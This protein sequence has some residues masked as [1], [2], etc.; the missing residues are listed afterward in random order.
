MALFLVFI[1]QKSF[2]LFSD[3]LP[4]FLIDLIQHFNISSFY[5]DMCHIFHCEHSKVF[6]NFREYKYIKITVFEEFFCI[7]LHRLQRNWLYLQWKKIVFMLEEEA[8]CS[9]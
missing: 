9:R 3:L 2:C 4:D 5:N 8:S 6:Q 7:M 1:S